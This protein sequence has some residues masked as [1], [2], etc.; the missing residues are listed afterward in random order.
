MVSAR[1]FSLLELT[2]AIAVVG[3]LATGAITAINV[4]KQL[5]KARDGTKKSDVA[6][7]Q[8]AF[9][10]YRADLRSYPTAATYNG[11]AC[12][13]SFAAG[14]PSVIYL[15]RMPC[16]PGSN[17]QKYTYTPVGSPPQTYTL[18]ATLENNSDSSYPT[19]TVS[20]P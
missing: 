16:S 15:T 18:T 14:S 20:N 10:L 4:P 7:I 11:V 5:Q 9:E 1:G 3:I 19:Y 2:I 17:P 8:A 13:Q 12:G 6:K